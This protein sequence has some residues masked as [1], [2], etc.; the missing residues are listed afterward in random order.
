MGSRVSDVVQG[1]TSL[2]SSLLE[3]WNALA[4]KSASKVDTGTY[5]ATSAAEDLSASVSLAAEGAG[6]WAAQ[7][8]DAAATL[9]GVEPQAN[10]VESDTFKTSLAGAALELTG[11]LLKGPG[12]EALPADAVTIDP[13]QLAAGA[14]DFVL[15]ADASG[16]RGATYAGTVKAS[17]AA[18]ATET[19]TVWITVP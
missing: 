4:A 11:P 13:A 16:Y 14:T 2:A 19:V 17:T 18:G 7:M 10:K 8:F 1:Y 12:L 3:R 5:D 9:A 15:R 6:L